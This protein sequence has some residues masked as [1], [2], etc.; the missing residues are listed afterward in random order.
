MYNP[1]HLKLRWPGAAPV[2]HQTAVLLLSGFC[3]ANSQKP[4]QRGAKNITTVPNTE[5]SLRCF[6]HQTFKN[7]NVWRPIWP[8][9]TNTTIQS[10]VFK[11]FREFID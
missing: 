9:G 3:D 6:D 1:H 11:L 7:N 4:I 10:Q 8:M 5:T 2:L